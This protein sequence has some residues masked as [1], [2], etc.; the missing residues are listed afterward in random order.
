M[1]GT[2]E[3][4]E[5]EK[6]PAPA[7]AGALDPEPSIASTLP[8]QPALQSQPTRLDSTDS[9]G[10]V[11]SEGSEIKDLLGELIGGGS[12]ETMEYESSQAVSALSELVAS[13]VPLTATHP[14]PLNP[15]SALRTPSLVAHAASFEDNSLAGRVCQAHSTKLVS[16]VC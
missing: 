15:P 3:A 5:N 11:D 13:V 9:L 1:T 2:S 8:A 10:P 14:D 12:N 16:H 4:P 6:A 7:R